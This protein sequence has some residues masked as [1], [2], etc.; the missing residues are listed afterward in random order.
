MK[1][2][3]KGR[4]GLR[5]LIDIALNSEAEPVSI[6]AIAERQSIS[7]S[8]LEQLTA[9]LKK[10]GFVDSVRG[11]KGGYVL[12]ASPDK[13][14]IGDVLR[15]LEG[16]LNPVDCPGLTDEGDGC[17]SSESCVTKYVWKRINESVKEAVDAITLR[18]LIE[19]AAVSG[20]D[21]SGKQNC[22]I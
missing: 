14:F 11:A 9:K 21:K 3:T 12:A 6:S 18:E 15:A 4:Y 8:Y 17:S 19:E 7:T 10:G 22:C 20:A 1:I 5:A 13:V 2:S 16:D